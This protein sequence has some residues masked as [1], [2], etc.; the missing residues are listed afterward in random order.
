MPNWCY[1]NVTLRANNV[2]NR[3]LLKEVADAANSGKE[4]FNLLRPMPDNI[5]QGNLGMAEREQ[6]G[7][8]N[9]YDWSVAHWGTKWDTDAQNVFYDGETLTLDLYDAAAVSGPK[10]GAVLVR[11]GAFTVGDKGEFENELENA[12]LE[13]IE[14]DGVGTE[15]LAGLDR[16]NIPI[17]DVF[18]QPLRLVDFEFVRLEPE[19][20]TGRKESLVNE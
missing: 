6:Q 7:E 1:N 12:G 11:G 16:V 15:A 17:F 19:A 3:A 18:E 5:F 8:N 2:G 13:D 14:E 20:L 9:W 4:I 10:P